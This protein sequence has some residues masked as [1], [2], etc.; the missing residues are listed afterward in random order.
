MVMGGRSRRLTCL[1][2]FQLR[3]SL[4][5]AQRF[6]AEASVALLSRSSISSNV[7]ATPHSSLS[8]IITRMTPYFHDWKRFCFVLREIAAGANGQPLSGIEAQERAQKVLAEVGYRWSEHL[9]DS[10]LS[11]LRD[12]RSPQ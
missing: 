3:L 9:P 2:R 8:I 1:R 7:L 4:T 5:R 11:P 12:H 10:A 6:S